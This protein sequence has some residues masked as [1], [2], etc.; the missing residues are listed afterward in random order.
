MDEFLN[1]HVKTVA[2]HGIRAG[3]QGRQSF[4][5]KATGWQNI[6][7]DVPN[8]PATKFRLGPII[9]EFTTAILQLQGSPN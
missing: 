2:V 9:K 5:R 6:E 1:A 4:W 3:D 7:L 8:T